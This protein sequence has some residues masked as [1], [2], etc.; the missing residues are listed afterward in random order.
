[1]NRDIKINATVDPSIVGGIILRFGSLALDGSL[2]NTFREAGE[3]LKN[4]AE[5]GE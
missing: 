2:Q 4:K 5:R 3:Q 1:M